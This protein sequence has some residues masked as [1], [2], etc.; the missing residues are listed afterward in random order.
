M[1]EADGRRQHDLSGLPRAEGMGHASAC[2]LGQPEKQHM[3]DSKPLPEGKEKEKGKEKG[4]GERAV[5]YTH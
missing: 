5:S 4:K 2:M 1:M 3:C